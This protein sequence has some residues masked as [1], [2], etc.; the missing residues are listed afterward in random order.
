MARVARGCTR[1]SLRH[2]FDGDSSWRRH[3]IC[4]SQFVSH[5]SL[6]WDSPL[7]RHPQVSSFTARAPQLR[8]V[9]ESPSVTHGHQ[10]QHP[11]HAFTSH[12]TLSRGNNKT[13]AGAPPSSAI[14][15]G[16]HAV[17]GPGRRST[18]SIQP[19]SSGIGRSRGRTSGGVQC[20][21]APDPTPQ[22]SSPYGSLACPPYVMWN[23]SSPLRCPLSLLLSCTIC[24]S[25][26][27][28]IRHGQ[29]PWEGRRVTG[30]SSSRGRSRNPG[31]VLEEGS[32]WLPVLK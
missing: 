19:G 7:L 29:L 8:W 27:C 18:G 17:Q 30:P 31:W 26:A 21:S 32:R 12:T 9:R 20:R 14:C 5:P 22:V 25:Q 3:N 2:L 16:R 15:V 4:F 13:D 28:T 10:H 1:G 23:A 24:L 6:T 11:E